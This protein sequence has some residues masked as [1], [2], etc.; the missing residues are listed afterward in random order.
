[1]Y[2]AAILGM[3]LFG[4]YGGLMLLGLPFGWSNQTW[5]ERLSYCFITGGLLVGFGYC[6]HCKTEALNRRPVI[7]KCV[8]L[9]NGNRY[10]LVDSTLRCK[11]GLEP[12]FCVV[13]R[14]PIIEIN[15]QVPCKNCGQLMLFHFDVASV[16]TDKEVEAQ[17]RIEYMNAPL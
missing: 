13:K 11:N 12:R 8:S 9:G 14:E 1:M 2:T 15:E 7:S 6:C 4:I 17:E 3:I 16:K 5:S 10:E